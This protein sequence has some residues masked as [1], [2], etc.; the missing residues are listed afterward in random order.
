MPRKSDTA[1]KAALA[2]DLTAM[3]KA[4]EARPVPDAIRSVVDQLDEGETVTP[5][6]RSR[7]RS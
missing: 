4:L 7:K 5:P 3:F 1:K 2:S 6:A